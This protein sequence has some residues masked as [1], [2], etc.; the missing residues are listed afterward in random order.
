[1]SLKPHRLYPPD[2]TFLAHEPTLQ[3]SLLIPARNAD[4]LERTVNETS[5]FLSQEYPNAHEIILIP[6]SADGDTGD[7]TRTIAEELV[8]RFSSVRSVPHRSAPGKGAAIRTGLEAARGK[9]IFFTDADLPYE[10]EFF[11]RA[12]QELSAGCGLV[13]GNRR[14]PDSHF[15]LPVGLL[16]VAY[17]RHRLGLSFNRVVRTLLPVRTTDTQAGIKAMSRKFA[18]DAFARLECPGFFFDVELFLAAEKLGYRQLELPVTLHLNTEKSTVRILRDSVLAAYW[19]TRI[20]RRHFRG[21]YG[22]V[23]D[24]FKV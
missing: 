22:P 21:D 23:K 17:G 14:L 20:A 6:N 11:S 16:P 13:T 18:R 24:R 4:T 2:D 8:R 15:N 12:A 10:L 5:R 3:V 19:L 1:M 9:W 7:R